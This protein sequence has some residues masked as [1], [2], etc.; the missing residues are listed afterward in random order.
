MQS[1]FH[2]Y[3]IWPEG[4]SILL[5]AGFSAIGDPFDW[6]V[7]EGVYES[8]RL[9]LSSQN[10][11]L[12]WH[13]L[14]AVSR[15]QN[16]QIKGLFV[17]AL[18]QRR[19]RLQDLAETFLP[20]NQLE[21]LQIQPGCL[22]DGKAEAA[23]QMLVDRGI[24]MDFDE[25]FDFLVYGSIA[26]DLEMANLLWAAGFRD[27]DNRQSGHPS[28]ALVGSE[29]TTTAQRLL[30]F[31]DWLITKGTDVHRT[32][33]PSDILSVLHYVA[34]EVGVQLPHLSKVKRPLSEEAERIKRMIFIDTARGTYDCACSLDGGNAVTSLLRGFFRARGFIYSPFDMLHEYPS[35]T[36]PLYKFVT[37]DLK[38]CFD[39]HA[40]AIIRAF[41]FQA[42]G[43]PHTCHFHSSHRDQMDGLECEEETTL[44]ED[45]MYEFL[46]MYEHLGM[47]L[48]SFLEDEWLK[49]MKEVLLI[50][51]PPSDEQINKIRELG[52][53]L[54]DI[55]LEEVDE[56]L[57]RV[58]DEKSLRG[59][60]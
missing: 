34:N 51:Q 37:D 6:A 40:E 25:E 43:I 42:L 38:D 57:V 30:E 32:R 9:L 5:Q 59:K 50:G 27:V 7:N 46:P 29:I 33:H 53:I 18:A 13:E 21:Q 22:L 58:D 55:D 31:T 60:T 11:H 1:A 56:E 19:T 48:L 16:S 52:V 41:T 54:D 12:G 17:N 45:L 10:M 8:V 23:Y 2:I 24:N 4:L 35:Y 15:S 3:T 39:T 49:R 20:S 28:Y 26:Q 36:Q 44:L 47:S 14:Y